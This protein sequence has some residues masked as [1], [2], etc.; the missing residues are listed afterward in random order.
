VTLLRAIGEAAQHL[1]YEAIVAPSAAG[2]GDV[3]AIFL[4]NRMAES[5]IE[6]VSAAP[7]ERA[8]DRPG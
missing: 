5:S 1:G 6:V 4:T 8:H 7:Y 2:A 3:V